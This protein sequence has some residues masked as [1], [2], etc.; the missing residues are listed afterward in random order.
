MISRNGR[1]KRSW[2]GIGSWETWGPI[3]FKWDRESSRF[4]GV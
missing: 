1:K 3:D 4:G 2:G